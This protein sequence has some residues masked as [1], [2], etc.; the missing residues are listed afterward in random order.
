MFPPRR[1]ALGSQAP[2]GLTGHVFAAVRRP[3]AAALLIVWAGQSF[4]ADVFLL[5]SWE[6]EVSRPGLPSACSYRLCPRGGSTGSSRG[7]SAKGRRPAAPP[8]RWASAC[9]FGGLSLFFEKRP[10][11]GLCLCGL[12]RPWVRRPPVWSVLHQQG[13]PV[14]CPRFDF[15]V[16]QEIRIPFVMLESVDRRVFPSRK[17]VR[18]ARSNSFLPDGLSPASGRVWNCGAGERS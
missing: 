10:F 14:F 18:S 6:Q 2:S 1:V 17:R 7:V 12:F 4:L 15:A 8:A 3:V 13:D 5:F 9:P 11:R 16:K